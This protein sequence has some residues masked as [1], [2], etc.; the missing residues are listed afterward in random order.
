[1]SFI[2]S[3]TVAD[4]AV[5]GVWI[6]GLPLGLWYL[7]SRRD[8]SDE[9]EAN[10]AVLELDRRETEIDVDQVAFGELRDWTA[11]PQ[12][13]SRDVWTWADRSD[14]TLALECRDCETVSTIQVGRPIPGRPEE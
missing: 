1:M 4:V 14:N 6:V 12:C 5:I 8:S 10:P 3:L 13:D 7:R 2:E 11:C 9:L